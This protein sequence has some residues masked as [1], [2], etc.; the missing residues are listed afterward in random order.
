MLGEADIKAKLSK[1]SQVR[2]C[3]QGPGEKWREGDGG[4]PGPGNGCE[5]A[6]NILDWPP[7]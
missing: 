7:R 6:K 2:S 3:S 4:Q 1:P 5:D